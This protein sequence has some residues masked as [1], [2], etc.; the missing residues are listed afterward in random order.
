MKTRDIVN[1]IESFADPGIQESWDNSGLIIGDPGSE[2]SGVLLCLDVTEAILDEAIE[3]GYNMIV[4]HHPPVFSGL[5]RF[6]GRDPVGRLVT[7]AIKNDLIIYSA[8]TNLDQV[9]DG[10]SGRIASKLGLVDTKILVPREDDLLKLVTFIPTDH[11]DK[12]SAAIFEAGAG[13]IGNYDSCGYSIDGTGSFR[14][15]EG[16]D[17]FS[18]KKGEMNYEEEKRFETIF[19]KHLKSGLIKRLLEVHPYEEVAYDIY[20]LKNSNPYMG[21]G[22]VG[23]LPEPV[24][25]QDFL[26]RVKEALNAGSIRHTDLLGKD[27]SRVAV[28]GGSGSEFLKYAKRAGADVYITADI[29]YHQF[30]DADDKILIMDVGHYESEHHALEVLNELI[31]KKLTNFAVRI[32]KISTNPINYF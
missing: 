15:G 17:P 14:A 11:F 3:I 22:I 32:S 2:V 20:P 31:L 9:Q 7:K 30:F 25:E 19:P 13:H 12:V 16:T 21:L 18:G 28:L 5:K 26:G 6:S 23:N 8:H 1:I 4:S 24:S 10:V 29:K 27:V